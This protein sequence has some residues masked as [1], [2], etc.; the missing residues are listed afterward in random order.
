MGYNKTSVRQLDREC[1]FPTA[2]RRG[3]S[4]LLSPQ[5]L[6]GDL[7]AMGS[8]GM[9]PCIDWTLPEASTSVGHTEGQVEAAF[10][11]PLCRDLH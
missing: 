7:V 3:G 8:L 5:Q 9:C 10:A 11:H 1:R 4:H 2:V 6:L